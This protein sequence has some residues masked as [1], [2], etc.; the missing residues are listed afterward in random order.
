MY[1]NELTSFC[2]VMNETKEDADG[3]LVAVCELPK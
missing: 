3:I 1:I 2:H